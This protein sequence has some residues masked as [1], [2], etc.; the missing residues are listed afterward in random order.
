MIFLLPATNKIN[1]VY[2]KRNVIYTKQASCKRC[3]LMQ[4]KQMDILNSS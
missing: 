4:H 1:K 2:G 3:Y